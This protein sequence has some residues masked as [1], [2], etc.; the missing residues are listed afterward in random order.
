[1]V[2][3]QCQAEFEQNQLS[4]V[5]KPHTVPTQ[6]IIRGDHLPIV[7]SVVGLSQCS[8]IEEKQRAQHQFI[9]LQMTA[10]YSQ[11][12]NNPLQHRSH[13]KFEDLNRLIWSEPV[14]VVRLLRR[15][16]ACSG[17]ICVASERTT[18]RTE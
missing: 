15:Q 3:Q 10:Q 17:A 14:Q 8:H 5:Q 11:S 7:M 9:A 18:T 16:Y 13:E 4:E 12:A 2:P 1:M 6:C